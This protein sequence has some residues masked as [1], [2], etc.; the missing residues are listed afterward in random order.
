MK[1]LTLL[2]ISISVCFSSEFDTITN[3]DLSDSVKVNKLNSFS[4]NDTYNFNSR[5]AALDSAFN[6]SHRNIYHFGKAFTYLNYAFLFLSVDSI[7]K[8]ID[9][10]EI[11]CIGLRDIKSYKELAESQYKLGEIY[12]SLDLFNK[13]N[14]I[15]F[16][17]INTYD[18]I[19]SKDDHIYGKIISNYNMLGKNDSALLYR[20][21]VKGKIDQ[22]L[23]QSRTFSL[24]QKKDVK[25]SILI[26]EL[27]NEIEK[28]KFRTD[29]ISFFLGILLFI[30]LLVIAYLIYKLK[31]ASKQI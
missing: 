30:S 7:T 26:K 24:A 28:A 4:R 9:Y 20:D 27:T 15:F 17:L 21:K 2:L 22:S 31:K 3:S 1:I 10:F 6:I 29:I 16:K 8:S 18:K 23:E 13:S 5:K 11:A 19:G 12:S 14:Q 25:N